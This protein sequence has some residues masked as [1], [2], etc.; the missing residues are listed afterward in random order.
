MDRCT[1]VDRQRT[2]FIAGLRCEVKINKIYS[3]MLS[4][5]RDMVGYVQVHAIIY[6]S[7]DK[8]QHG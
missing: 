3:S 7:N 1:K 6:Y 8:R 5:Y 4:I 2:G